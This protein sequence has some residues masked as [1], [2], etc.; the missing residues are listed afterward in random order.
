MGTYR[1]MT[2]TAT[3]NIFIVIDNFIDLLLN[4][5]FEMGLHFFVFFFRR[6]S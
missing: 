5:D 3:G 4:E 2:R 1:I 6:R